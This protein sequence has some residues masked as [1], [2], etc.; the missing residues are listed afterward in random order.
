MSKLRLTMFRVNVSGVAVNGWTLPFGK[1]EI[2]SIFLCFQNS[3]NMLLWGP[4]SDQ[5][6]KPSGL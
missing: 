6:G 2:E 4:T 3:V 5:N 1:T